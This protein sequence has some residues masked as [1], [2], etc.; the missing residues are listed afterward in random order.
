[1]STPATPAK[2]FWDSPLHDLFQTLEATPAGLTSDEANR[3][4]RL[5]GPNSFVRESRF[6]ALFSFLRLVANPLVIIVVLA[7]TISIV[8]GDHIGGLIIV[9]IAGDFTPGTM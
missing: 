4:L 9:S 1:M 5:Y 7:S 8:R 3:R 2:D 6:A